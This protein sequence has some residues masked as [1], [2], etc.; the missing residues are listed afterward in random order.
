MKTKHTQAF[1]L[2]R[3]VLSAFCLMALLVPL[4]GYG[5]DTGTVKGKII[6]KS[7]GEG[8]FGASVT[9]AGTTLGT[10]TDMN[11]NFTLPNVPAKQQKVSISIVGY[12]P[13]SQTLTVT[14]GETT[15]VNL[16][17][18]QTTIM[19][20]EVVVGASLYKQDRLD[21]PVTANVV[22]KEKIKQESSPTLDKVIA[23]VPGV[24]VTRSGGTSS[25]SLQ[26][27]GSNSFD[28]GGIGTRV[29]GHYDGFPVNAPES[30]E[31][32]WQSINMNAADK[33]EVLK[34]AAATLYGSGAMGGVVNVT[35]H[36]PEKFEIKAGS[37]IGFY[38]K[39][40]KSDQSLYRQNYTPLFWNSY[41][42]MGN[43]QG[44]WSY[45]LLYS[46]NDD[47]GHR[48]NSKNKMDD[49][50]LK[51]RYDID[52]KQY[53][54]L[55]SF[56]TSTVGGYAYYWPYNTATTFGAPTMTPIAAHAYDVSRSFSGIGTIPLYYTSLSDYNAAKTAATGVAFAAG[57]PGSPAFTTAY[58]N[59]L[60]AQGVPLYSS[61]YDGIY[62]DD[63]IKRK[64]CL[65]GLNYVNLLSDNLSLDTRLY[66][67][68]NLTRYEY[69]N[70][71]ANQ[72][73]PTGGELYNTYYYL[74]YT[75]GVGVA[76]KTLDGTD[77]SYP[78]L[79]IPGQFNETRNSRY[80]AGAKVD[81]KATPEHRMLFG[82]D[83]N[84]VKTTT[85]QVAA[86]YPVT[87]QFNDIQE[88][89]AAAFLQDEWKMTNKLTSLMSLR[90]DWSGINADNVYTTATASVPLNNKSVDALSPRVAVNYKATD[91]MA[92]RASWGKSFRAP[93]LYERFIREAVIF[94]GTPNPNLGKETLT[95]WEAGVFKQFGDRVSVDISGFVNNYDDLIESEIIGSSF[96]YKNITKARIYGIETNINLRPVDDISMN[97][98]YT[99]MNAKN[100]SY[101][102]GASST[103]D[104]NPDPRWL[105]YRPEH[106]ASANVT[107]RT[108]KALALNV[109]G[110]YVS[111]YNAITNFT[112][113][114]GDYYPGNFVVYNLG[115]KYKIYENCTAT[116]TCNNINNTQYEEVVWFRAPGRSFVAG[117][118][119]TF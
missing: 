81:W 49:V 15:V 6:D 104:A 32:V 55:S 48:E 10:A 75:P 84:I 37:S 69:N 13:A 60:S 83:G 24:V 18:G 25:S 73:Y 113:L 3:F 116:F 71:N 5:A 58:S 103:N 79:R 100:R 26:I 34:G 98:A 114:Q 63:L 22:S 52:A 28:G 20:S 77:P 102:A 65:I 109:N 30:G 105:P 47:D 40:P 85:T 50:K 82:V 4:P 74:G 57:L 27:R 91:D 53:L 45:D 107:W 51:T 42:G 33:V 19:A 46:H 39:T 101:V 106:T 87:N 89:N 61:T 110:R 90:Y 16:Q 59:Y 43:K 17:L 76:D 7:D 2:V 64:N 112:N 111:K 94:I 80:G 92:L 67:T 31:I 56:Y 70:T 117:V 1:R 62:S 54:Q 9:I 11:G 96:Q 72:I 68:N 12:A 35:G 86:E 78:S 95:A 108:T 14:S 8:V 93:T 88:R 21:V 66:Y 97:L 29:Q 115:A 36:L 23:D 41:I 119:F 99:Y 38:D 44:K 118:D